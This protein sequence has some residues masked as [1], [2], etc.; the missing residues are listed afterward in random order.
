MAQE[1]KTVALFRLIRLL[2]T[3]PAKNLKTLSKTLGVDERTM[4]RY[5][6]EDLPNLS[7]PVQK[8]KNKCYSLPD[9]KHLPLN[10]SY[11]LSIEEALFLK[12]ALIGVQSSSL[13]DSLMAKVFQDS[14]LKSISDAFVKITNTQTMQR[15]GNAI[16]E[17]RQ[18][19]ALRDCSPLPKTLLGR[20]S[21]GTQPTA[22][23]GATPPGL[24]EHC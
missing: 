6:Q 9:L 4:R 22:A 20:A 14:E 12:D 8:D 10:L 2:L 15:L 23:T 3:S 1:V 13:K 5:V 16:R 11:G 17:G 21:S 7:F 18:V 19:P 24:D